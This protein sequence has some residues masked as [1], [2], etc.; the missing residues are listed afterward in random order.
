MRKFR[1]FGVPVS[2][3][4][5]CFMCAGVL[6]CVAVCCS[7][8]QCVAVCCSVLQCVAVCC[9]VLIPLGCLM[10]A[11]VLR[12]VAVCCSISQKVEVCRRVLQHLSSCRYTVVNMY[13][14][15]HVYIYIYTCV[16]VYVCT[17][18]HIY[19]CICIYIYIHVYIYIC[20]YIN[21]KNI[22]THCN[23]HT[24]LTPHGT[25]CE[26]FSFFSHI[27]GIPTITFQILWQW[28]CHG[29]HLAGRSLC[30]FRT[31]PASLGY[32]P[33]LFK[34]KLFSQRESRYSK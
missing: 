9:S 23:T 19:M 32:P 13:I 1:F 8:L 5:G 28:L 34:Y 14:C 17:Y 30:F 21:S 25:L 27:I 20:A 4:L 16:H 12:C 18:T 6:Q 10:C 11:G 22:S 26:F 15:T 2:T 7:V 33:S 3:P 29:S 24:T 31:T